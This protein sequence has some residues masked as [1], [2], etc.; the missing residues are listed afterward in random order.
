MEWIL[1]FLDPGSGFFQ[2]DQEW[3]FFSV[4]GSGLDFV[5]TEKTLLVVCLT[6][7]YLDSNRCRIAWISLWTATEQI[8]TAT[9]KQSSAWMRKGYHFES[10]STIYSYFE[11]EFGLKPAVCSCL[12]NAL[13]P[14]PIALESCSRAQTDRKKIFGW[15][16]IA[17]SMRFLQIRTWRQL[18]Q[19]VRVQKRG[20]M[21]LF[22]AEFF[23]K[24][25][26]WQ[27]PGSLQYVCYVAI[28]NLERHVRKASHRGSKQQLRSCVAI[29][30]IIAFSRHAYIVL[31]FA[32]IPFVVHHTINATPPERLQQLLS[33]L[34]NL[35]FLQLPYNTLT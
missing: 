8:W 14:P 29:S 31:F 7:I 24:S 33:I 22:V 6:Y 25:T 1:I 19:R 15:L 35:T 9:E 32:H 20:V 34:A 13:A 3:C 18:Y 11:F 26:L 27:R 30:L 2:Q 5:F 4:A 17:W 23:S 21:K 10:R 12:T 16:V 28:G